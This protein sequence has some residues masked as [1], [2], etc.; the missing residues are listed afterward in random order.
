M[1][2]GLSYCKS[3][4][5]YQC[6]CLFIIFFG[7]VVYNFCRIQNYSATYYNIYL[8]KRDNSS[9]KVEHSHYKKSI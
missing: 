4:K 3:V 1:Y 9:K 2:I 5:L 7:R 8:K 6:K